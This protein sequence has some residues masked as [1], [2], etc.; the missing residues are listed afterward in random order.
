MDDPIYAPPVSA[1]PNDADDS[2]NRNRPRRPA[3]K[4]APGQVSFLVLIPD[5]PGRGIIG[6]DGAVV[7]H[8]QR[9]TGTRIHFDVPAPGSD[10]R[11]VSVAGSGAVDRRIALLHGGEE[12]R[13]VSSAQEAML[14]VWEAVALSEGGAMGGEVC[15]RLLAHTSQIGAVM[16]K[17]GKNI[18]R[19]KSDSGAKFIRIL[20]AH[21]HSTAND[22]QLI[23]IVGGILAVKKALIDVS[24]SLQDKTPSPLN[25]P[26]GGSSSGASPDE[27]FP[28]LSALLPALPGENSYS[29]GNTW[30]SDAVSAQELNDKQEVIFR[31][32]CS[33]NAAG[34]VIGKKGTIVRAMQN[35]AGASIMFAAPLT[36]SRERV[37]TISAWENIESCHSSAQKAVALVFSRIVEGIVERYPSGWSQGRPVTAKLLV[38]SD[39]VG[40]LGGNEGEVLS[41]M[42]GLTGADIRILEGDHI[43]NCA[44]GNDV[45]VQ[46]TGEY[47]SVQD[48]LFQ[49]TCSLRDNLLP[50]EVRKAVRAKY[51]YIRLIVDPLRN[52]PVPHNIGALSP[53]RL[54]FPKTLGRGQ[55]TAI[56]DGGSGLRTFGEDLQLG[57]GHNLTTVANTSVE[58]LISEHVFSSVYGEDG[59][60]LDRIIQVQKLKCMILVLAKERGGLLYQGH[61]IKPLW[62]RACFKPSSKV[63]GEHHSISLITFDHRVN[64]RWLD[65]AAYVNCHLGGASPCAF[66]ILLCRFPVI[67]SSAYSKE[68]VQEIPPCR[69]YL[70]AKTKYTSFIY[71]YIYILTCELD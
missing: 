3:T 59:S 10:Q 63:Q 55:T 46:I 44:S 48:A 50:G 15:C 43:R 38:A 60:N 2:F 33:N 28:N 53:S 35:E 62:P 68:R 19:V 32:L 40:C 7:S 8:I 22:H 5:S 39:L 64:G 18:K 67:I 17:G 42:R 24:T 29:N 6:N 11:V 34:Y 1:Y 45:V 4:L 49:V 21:P 31:M 65:F 16:G 25:R 20:R 26:I 13:G 27:F 37:V 57:S 12:L 51:P 71:I 47:R 61:L 36:E 70:K 23:Q 9:E 58:I 14:R 54:P 56:S 30:S 41:E 69:F 52:D 66:N